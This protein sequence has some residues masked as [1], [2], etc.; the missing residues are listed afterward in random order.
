MLRALIVLL[1]LVNGLV[2]LWGEGY[3]QDYWPLPDHQ[4][5]SQPYRKLDQYEPERLILLPNLPAST[6]VASVATELGVMPS[7]VVTASGLKE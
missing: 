2:W 4:D 1:L 7:P 5:S 6:P 3:L